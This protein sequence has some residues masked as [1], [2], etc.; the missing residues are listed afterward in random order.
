MPTDKGSPAVSSRT[1]GGQQQAAPRTP[2]LDV[3]LSQVLRQMFNINSYAYPVPSTV[4]RPFSV[5]IFLL[6]L[7]L[8][9][10]VI[11]IFF[12]I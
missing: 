9:S 2:T 10:S 11:S 5:R 6:G 4:A 8:F 7:I 12:L 3:K 1:C